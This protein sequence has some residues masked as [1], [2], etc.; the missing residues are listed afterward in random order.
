MHCILRMKKVKDMQK[1]LAAIEHNMRLRHQANIDATQSHKNQILVNTLNADLTNRTDFYHKLENF[2]DDQGVK[3][4]ADNVLLNEFVVSASP[5]FFKEKTD[6]EIQEWTDHQVDF[7]KK[8]FGENLKMGVLHL[9]ESTPHIHFMVSTEQTSVKKYK[10]QKGEFFKTTT[11]LNAKRWGP[12]FLIE[13]HDRH[14]LHNN[15]FGLKRGQKKSDKIHKTVKEFYAELAKKEAELDIQMAEAVKSKKFKD[16]F[17]T[18]K[19]TILNSYEAI[20]DLLNIIESKD[21]SDD[22]IEVIS[23]IAK[24]VPKEKTEIKNKI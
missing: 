18:L 20:K 16:A 19:Q 12:Q 24:K 3:K 15:K 9:D 7:F 4:R 5:E 1:I 13:L 21:L 11:A 10:N 8:E 14:A 17:P 23:N 22:E 6:A 2:Y